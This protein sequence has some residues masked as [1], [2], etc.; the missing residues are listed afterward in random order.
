MQVDDE[1][2]QKSL[3]RFP[4]QESYELGQEL[5]LRGS[6]SKEPKAWLVRKEAMRVKS[7][8]TDG[9][10]KTTPTVILAMT[11]DADNVVSGL[12]G[13]WKLKMIDAEDVESESRPILGSGSQ[14][15]MESPTKEIVD[16]GERSNRQ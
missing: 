6:N 9:R 10:R 14:N 13:E 15:G 11:V 16:E 3:G 2:Q 4:P 5:E 12:L 7:S 1:E 8:R